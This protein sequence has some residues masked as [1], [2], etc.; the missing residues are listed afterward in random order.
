M[1]L[2]LGLSSLAAILIAPFAWGAGD[3]VGLSPWM[4]SA[5]A[6]AF[7]VPGLVIADQLIR[8]IRSK[9]A[10]SFALSATLLFYGLL[11]IPVAIVVLVTIT[12]GVS[13]SGTY[14]QL[15]GNSDDALSPAAYMAVMLG[16]AGLLNALVGAASATYLS[17]IS[18]QRPG[19]H[20]RKDGE[21]DGVGEMLS[22]R[23]QTM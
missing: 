21:V 7:G 2:L 13:N 19:R 1:P 23:N 9:T 4:P 11:A 14:D 6:L 17:A 22:R 16:V 15:Q 8:R 12:A 18:E 20:D 5:T 10:G 3:H